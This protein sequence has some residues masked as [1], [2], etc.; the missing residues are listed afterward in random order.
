M[1][2]D[3][4][5]TLYQYH[6]WARD[7]LLRA[8]G[9]L[10]H[11]QLTAMTRLGGLRAMFVHMIGSEWIW[12]SRWQ[13]VSPTTRPAEADFPNLE[14]IRMRWHEEEQAIRAFVATLRDE[15]LARVVA[16]TTLTGEPRATPLWQILAHTANHGTQHRSEVALILTELGHSPGDL[17]MIVFFAE[18]GNRLAQPSA[19]PIA[20]VSDEQ[21]FRVF[22]E[23]SPDA[24]FVEDLSGVVLEV[25]DAACRLHD[26]PRE[27][28]LGKNVADLVPTEQRQSVIEN[29]PRLGTGQLEHFEGFSWTRDGQAIPVEVRAS[30]IEYRQRP[31]VLL[32][33]RDISERKQAENEQSRLQEEII[34]M[35]ATALAELSTPLIPISDDV[36]VMPLIGTIDARRAE[37]IVDTL[38]EDVAGSQARIAI[39]DITGVAL[40]DTHVANTL[41]RAAQAIRLL[42]AQVVLTGIRPEVAQALVGLGV[43]LSALVTRSTLQSGIVYAMGRR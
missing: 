40:V 24:I 21:F 33:V 25:N 7:R 31:V 4:F 10:S 28:I 17:D 42:G 27:E 38:L 6:Y 2:A 8:A 11:E 1:H 5:R 43:D 34:R 18:T 39:L 15:D 37:Q 3:Y 19:P 41:I 22:F 35:Q 9:A 13:G 26:L 30:R 16:Y 32:I 14:A 12:R 29:F 20:P 36:L 23:R